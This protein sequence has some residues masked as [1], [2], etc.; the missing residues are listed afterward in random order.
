MGN[1]SSEHIVEGKVT[2]ATGTSWRFKCLY[3]IFIFFIQFSL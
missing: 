3:E 1:K 2:D